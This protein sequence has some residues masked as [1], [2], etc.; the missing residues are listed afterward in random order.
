MP[1]SS[2]YHSLLKLNT[3]TDH[4]VYLQIYDKDY[5]LLNIGFQKRS[6]PTESI[7]AY[8]VLRRREWPIFL[9]VLHIYSFSQSG[10]KRISIEFPCLKLIQFLYIQSLYI[11]CIDYKV[12]YLCTFHKPKCLFL[13]RSNIQFVKFSHLRNSHLPLNF[14]TYF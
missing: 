14:P 4:N 11:F 10:S 5:I 9:Y 8:V 1:F 13:Q 2:V 7:S 12:K 6:R 3:N